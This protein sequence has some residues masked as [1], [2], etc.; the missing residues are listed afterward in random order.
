[1][2]AS[3]THVKFDLSGQYT[4]HN[5]KGQATITIHSH[6]LTG[7]PGYVGR[8]GTDGLCKYE[9]RSDSIESMTLEPP[10][11]KWASTA[12]IVDVTKQHH[13]V[14]VAQNVQLQL[15][16]DAHG[17]TSTF[18]VQVIDNKQ[19]LWFSNNWTGLKTAVSETVPAIQGG[20]IK[21]GNN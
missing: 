8:P 2:P 17:H 20:K 10:L 7:I 9:I 13:H 1:M 3:G 4:Q 14:K 16:M 19:G 21:L 12:T 15:V 6:P 18:S 11:E 5:L